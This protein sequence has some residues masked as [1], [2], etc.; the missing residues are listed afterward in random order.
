MS[1]QEVPE[2][3]ATSEAPAESKPEKKSHKK[4]PFEA[5]ERGFLTKAQRAKVVVVTDEGDPLF[6]P[7]VRDPEDLSDTLARLGWLETNPL[8]LLPDGRVWS[9]RT[10]FLSLE[11]AEK[12][13]GHEIKVPYLV[14]EVDEEQ[15]AD[16]TDALDIRVQKLNPMVIAEK[17]LRSLSRGKS[18]KEIYELTGIKVDDQHGY[19]L[20]M[21]EDK[22]PPN[23][24]ELVRSGLLSFGA[25]VELARKAA[26]MTKAEQTALAEQ[27]A[28][29]AAGGVKVT[30]REVARKA[31]DDEGPATQ[32]QKKQF[33][34]D[35]QSDKLGG[36]HGDAVTYALIIGLEVGLGTRTIKSAKAAAGK[37]ARGES[38]KVDFKQYQ[39]K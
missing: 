36:K 35:L 24:Q 28:K 14:V 1:E 18:E 4:T 26:D 12:R 20:L 7:K 10:K 8:T 11:K 30:A 33:L 23:I 9:G 34:L 6:N 38:V 31:G 17:I 29:A 39:T 3:P 5:D 16:A 19:L 37:L 32:K 15:G 22:C 2:T 27:I 13:A 25:A 21:D